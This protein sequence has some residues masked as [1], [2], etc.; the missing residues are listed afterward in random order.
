MPGECGGVPHVRGEAI[1]FFSILSQRILTKN[2]DGRGWGVHTAAVAGREGVA[3][4]RVLNSREKRP[5]GDRGTT[6]S[7][8]GC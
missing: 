8:C 1:R 6:R 2:N 5:A 3:G 7:E 4:S